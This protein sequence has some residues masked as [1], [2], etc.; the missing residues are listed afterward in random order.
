MKVLSIRQP[1]A[2]FI[3]ANGPNWKRVENR[4]W[5]T[6]YR[7]WLYIHASKGVTEEEYAEARKFAIKCGVYLIPPYADLLRG[8]IIG[9]VRLAGC[10]RRHESRWFTGPFGFVLSHRYP[11]PFEPCAGQRGLYD[12]GTFAPQKWAK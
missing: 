5:P 4:S 2:S 9:M 10:V 6:D 12:Y 7:G 8:G 1:W 3:F 11:L